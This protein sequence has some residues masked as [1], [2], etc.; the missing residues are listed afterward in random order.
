MS[1]SNLKLISIGF[2]KLPDI[3]KNRMNKYVTTES[4]NKRISVTANIPDSIFDYINEN[5]YGNRSL[6][7]RTALI[8]LI[9]V[10][11]DKYP[12]GKKLF[13]GRTDLMRHAVINEILFNNDSKKYNNNTF[14]EKSQ[15]ISRKFLKHKK[16]KIVINLFKNDLIKNHIISFLNERGTL[17]YTDLSG[18]FFMASGVMIHTTI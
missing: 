13:Q 18:I 3:I 16:P 2:T 12:N 5:Y 7:A 14:T 4:N 1:N 11:D 8:N 10:L 17:T 15:H 6:F 9:K